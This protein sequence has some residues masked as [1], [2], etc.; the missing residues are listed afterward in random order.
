M[1]IG[2]IRLLDGLVSPHPICDD[3]D[4]KFSNNGDSGKDEATTRTDPSEEAIA[5]KLFGA[6][7]EFSREI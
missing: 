1:S 4:K 3:G 5:S 2:K 7:F 6:K